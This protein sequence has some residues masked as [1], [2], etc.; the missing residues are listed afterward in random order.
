MVVG[1]VCMNRYRL[2]RGSASYLQFSKNNKNQLQN[3][4]K[5]LILWGEPLLILHR[6]WRGWLLNGIP[7]THLKEHIVDRTQMFKCFGCF[8]KC[9]PQ[10]GGEHSSM[11]K[12]NVSFLKDGSGDSTFAF[13]YSHQRIVPGP[14]RFF[15]FMGASIFQ[16]LICVDGVFFVSQ[17]AGARKKRQGGMAYAHHITTNPQAADF[18]CVAF[19]ALF[20]SCQLGV[21]ELRA[22]ITKQPTSQKPCRLLLGTWQ[23]E[24]CNWQ[25]A[26][27]N[28][29]IEIMD[30]SSLWI[31]IGAHNYQSPMWNMQRFYRWG[32]WCSSPKSFQR[33]SQPNLACTT[34]LKVQ[35]N[36]CLSMVV[37]W[38]CT[39]R[40]CWCR[41]RS[42]YLQFF[43][44]NKNQFQKQ[45]NKKN[46][47]WGRSIVILR[48]SYVGLF[49]CLLNN[50]LK[51]TCCSHTALFWMLFVFL[52]MYAP[53]RWRTLQQVQW[54]CGCSIKPIVLEF[55][56][57]LF[58]YSHQRVVPGPSRFPAFMGDIIFQQ[59]VCIDCVFCVSQGQGPERRGRG[60]AYAIDNQPNQN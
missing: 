59:L 51:S 3:K 1:W 50:A 17:G 58:R 60:M 34:P 21:V 25:I 11:Y 28:G 22:G 12:E 35:L 24:R 31:C 19:A 23:C 37:G 42:S 38:V 53:S 52:Q 5:K 8:Y 2:C 43:K 26:M 40:Y 10:V 13:R 33:F 56:P 49:A 45:K 6:S 32:A 47:M 9:M 55:P 4:T 27:C 46:I 30:S 57:S 29:Q 44:K 14:S 41:G 7:K 36:I 54:K 16:Q 18:S 20:F 48:L 39:N 15:A